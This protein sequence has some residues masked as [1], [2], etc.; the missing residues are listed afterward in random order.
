MV[1][2]VSEVGKRGEWVN[3][4]KTHHIDVYEIVK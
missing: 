4:V 3:T 1:T 2:T